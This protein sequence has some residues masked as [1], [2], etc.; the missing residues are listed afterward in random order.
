MHYSW[1]YLKVSKHTVR[2]ITLILHKLCNKLNTG[3][4]NIIISLSFENVQERLDYSLLKFLSKS[5]SYKILAHQIFLLYSFRNTVWNLEMGYHQKCLTVCKYMT[6]KKFM[7][8]CR[9]FSYCLSKKCDFR[10]SKNTFKSYWKVNIRI[11]YSF[12]NNVT[13]NVRFYSKFSNVSFYSIAIV[14]KIY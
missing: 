5:Y 11:L 13:L 7:I 9:F 14:S 6:P 12:T 10:Y 4:W 1:R 3:C 8:T 2:M